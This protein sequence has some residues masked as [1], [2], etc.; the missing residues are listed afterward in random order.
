MLCLRARVA[1]AL[2]ILGAAR[3]SAQRASD[4]AGTHLLSRLVT[5]GSP[6]EDGLRNAQLLGRP[7]SFP[8]LMRAA[9]LRDADTTARSLRRLRWNWISPIVELT[10]NSDIAFSL[11][12]GAQWAGRG[13]TSSVLGGVHARVGRV[14]VS[15][16]PQVWSTQNR[17]FVVLPGADPSRNGFASPW[18]AGLVSADLPQRFGYRSTT[19]FGLGE[20]AA[21]FSGKRVTAGLSSE[22][23]WWGPGIRNALVMSNNAGGIP[24]AFVRTTSPIRLHGGDLEARWI[25]GALSE[26]RFF[27]SNPANDLRSLSGGIVT[28]SPAL[29]R[30]LTAGIA[31]VVYANIGG[32]EALPARGLDVLLRWG[33][34]FNV[35]AA[36]GGRAAEQLTSLF[37][38]WVLPSSAAEVYGEWARIL[39]PTSVKSV[40]VAPQFTQGFTVGLQWL[41]ALGSDRHLRL[42]A[43]L[44]NLEQSPPSRA[45]DTLSFYA[46]SVVPQGYT[47]RGQVIGAA[48]GPGSS[49]QWL[50]LDY[51]TGARSAGVF[52]GR[53]R[54]DTDAYYRQPTSVLYFAYD[55]SLFGG[56]RATSHLMGR[57]IAAELWFQHRYNYL[58][59]NPDFGFSRAGTFDRDN[60]TA[61]LRV[62]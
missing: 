42:Q 38:R 3:I 19:A 22:A 47:Q 60:V 36:S 10:W 54:W 15:V 34:G 5:V 23:Q 6:E 52:G 46:S 35:R 2:L 61:R 1:A 29:E 14:A 43:E 44:T 37:G 40:L 28:F 57:A 25:I 50:A 12:D 48:I 45:D 53:I 7:S 27:D 32:L 58:F 33:S 49:S 13:L 4:S 30:N 26:S 8:M 59:Q 20:S 18:H 62:H 41:P 21:W 11:N 17:P 55:V 9:H 24:H 31:R 56:L 39:L 51:L 16:V